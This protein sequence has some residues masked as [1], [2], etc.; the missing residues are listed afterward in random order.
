MENIDKNILIRA[1][2]GDLEAFEYILS[3][4]EKAI[5]NYCL[6]ILKNSTH[7]K[8]VTQETFIK[9]YTHRKK[10]DPEKNIK[11]W[12]FTIATNTA[13]DF[14]RSKKRKMEISLDEEFETNSSFETYYQSKEEGLISDVDKALTQIKS[15]YK[16]VLLLFYQQGFE[17]KEIA[18]ILGMPINTVKTHISRGREQLKELLKEYG[19][20]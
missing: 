17:Y 1:K 4:Y 5:Y 7:A 8:D 11:T 3:F 20:D 13:Y 19:K 18:E 12:I 6:R 9:V 14:L 2:A 15:E 10:I 16:K